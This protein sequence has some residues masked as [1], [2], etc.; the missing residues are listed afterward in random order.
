MPE[1]IRSAE[2]DAAAFT[3]DD[4]SPPIGRRAFLAWA[5]AASLGASVLFM[6]ATV[7]QA[8]VPPK[9]SISGKTTVGRLTV[10]RVA[11]L[12]VGSAV[13]AEYGDD[14]L[15]VVRSGENTFAVFD[16]ACPHVGCT[17]RFDAK[18][19]RFVCPCH[20]STFTIDGRRLGGPAPRD[21][22]AATFEVVGGEV[23]VSGLRS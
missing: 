23:V 10:A 4:A 5:A 22:T 16:S 15:W 14:T 11:D 12:K 13:L 21:L 2:D 20:E 3:S 9:R 18:A 19:Q 17:L 1:P 8:I 7:I 6:G